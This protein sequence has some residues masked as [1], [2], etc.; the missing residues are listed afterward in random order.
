M[1]EQRCPHCGGDVS[2]LFRAV[3]VDCGADI[4]IGQGFGVSAEEWPDKSK[5]R[6]I[7][8]TPLCLSCTSKRLCQ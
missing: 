6:P 1:K 5:S 4:P 3:C 8:I 7:T 2:A